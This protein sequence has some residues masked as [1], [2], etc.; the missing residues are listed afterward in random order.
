MEDLK[1]LPQTELISRL[2]YIYEELDRRT[3]NNS[4]KKNEIINTIRQKFMDRLVAVKN[5]I[6]SIR[7]REFEVCI[8]V[9]SDLSITLNGGEVFYETYPYFDEDDIYECEIIEKETDKMLNKV[10]AV[11]LKVLKEAKK[12]VAGQNISEFDVV[13]E[14]F[15]GII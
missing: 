9:K 1:N 7:N 5:D 3:D 2:K 11:V 10:K 14:V 8:T 15:R 4:S 6:A 13:D 12:M